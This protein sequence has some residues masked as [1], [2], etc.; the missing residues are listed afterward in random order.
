VLT[1]GEVPHIKH[2]RW[3]TWLH[4]TTPS[5]YKL[6]TVQQLCCTFKHWHFHS[7]PN[8]PTDRKTLSFRSF[9]ILHTLKLRIIARFLNIV[10]GPNDACV[11]IASQI[12]SFAM[13][14]SLMI[15]K[16]NLRCFGGLQRTTPYIMTVGSTDEVIVH[17][18]TLSL[19]SLS[20]SLCIQP[21]KNSPIS[22]SFK[23]IIFEFFFT[24]NMPRNA[25][26]TCR[27]VR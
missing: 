21:C 7:N 20:L 13:L 1:V 23:K 27:Y 2:Y 12:R 25:V 6:R 10:R 19:S 16:L 22:N 11:V 26:L 9:S 14:I 5:T 15:G 24:E 3:H 8:P 18:N 17:I 4:S